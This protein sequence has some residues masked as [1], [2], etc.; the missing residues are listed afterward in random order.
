MIDNV[1]KI[2]IIGGPGTGKSTLARNLGKELNIPVYHIDAINYLKNWQ[3][4]DKSERD[5]IILE[6]ICQ[7]KWIMDGTYMGTLNERIKASDC[8]IFLDYSTM[9]KLKGVIS[10][11][12]KD[13]GKEKLDI[14][15]CKEKW[16]LWLLKHALKW[17]STKR[18][19]IIQNLECNNEKEILIF[20]NRINLNKWYK[21]EFNKNID[22]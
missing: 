11:F 21:S 4:R 22:L 13:N 1:N 16:S 18:K 15:G 9:A 19:V 10:R 5:K 7:A 3:A 2:T 14:P 6:K 17:N 8:V 20:K 12:F